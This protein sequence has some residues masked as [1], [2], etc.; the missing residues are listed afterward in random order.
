MFF[1]IIKT[2]ECRGVGKK[3]KQMKAMEMETGTEKI[4]QTKQKEETYLNAL[5]RPMEY[6]TDGK[7]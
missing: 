5:R 1:S 4:K 3:T 2:N 6:K 7:S